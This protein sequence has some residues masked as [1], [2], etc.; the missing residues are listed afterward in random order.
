MS[1]ENKL[2]G[3]RDTAKKTSKLVC[4][5]ITLQLILAPAANA[6]DVLTA[7]EL[8]S[9]CALLSTH[10]DHTDGQY[11][12]RYIQGFIDG[13]VATDTQ[14]IPNAESSL[15]GNETFAERAM[16]TRMPDRGDLSTVAKLTEFC[17]GKSLPLSDVV[18][19]VVADL[20]QL[21]TDKV[22]DDP[23]MEVVYKSLLKNFPCKQ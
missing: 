6:L 11:C 3:L 1:L 22:K 13:A 12:T 19:K 17:L 18:D 2:L 20:S 14:V 23:A 9:Y 16:R 7:K 4:A 15:S 21:K 8:S 10:P 5:L